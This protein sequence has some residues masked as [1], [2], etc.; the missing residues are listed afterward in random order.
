[1]RKHL[2]LS[3]RRFIQFSTQQFA[4]SRVSTSE[5]LL[6]DRAFILHSNQSVHVITKRP[7]RV[8]ITCRQRLSMNLLSLLSNVSTQLGSE[9]IFCFYYSVDEEELGVFSERIE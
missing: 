2:L 7:T 3:A 6:V 8:V 5:R 1:M 9:K 4:S